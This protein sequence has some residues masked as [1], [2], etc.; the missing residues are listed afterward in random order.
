MLFSVRGA[1]TLRRHVAVRSILEPA[2]SATV[3][4]IASN[5]LTYPIES[6][7]LIN[8]MP[9]EQQETDPSLRLTWKNLYRGYPQYL[10]YSMCNYWITYQVMFFFL[11]ALQTWLGSYEAALTG[12][13]IGTCMVTSLYKVPC[14]YFFKNKVVN[15]RI[16]FRT[17]WSQA[18]FGKAYLILL[19][20]DIPEMFIKFY[21]SYGLRLLFP[22]LHDLIQALC[23]G[24]ISTMILTPIDLMKNAVLCNLPGPPKPI[25]VYLRV[26][27]SVV[28]TTLFFVFFHALAGG[29]H[30]AG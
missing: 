25:L 10:P 16:C 21:L 11:Q 30:I 7:R 5:T 20:E 18:L 14:M 29:G 17:F 13:S 6:V 9:K 3:S 26:L 1:P 22:Q 23:I 12:A 15:Q 28:N 4:K 2:L 19:L 27:C 24:M 8:M